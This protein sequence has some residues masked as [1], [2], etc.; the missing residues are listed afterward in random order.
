MIQ[1]LNFGVLAKYMTMNIGSQNLMRLLSS[2]H[3]YKWN[4][5]NQ[6]K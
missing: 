2:F 4:A 3:Y 6:I 1:V 5:S